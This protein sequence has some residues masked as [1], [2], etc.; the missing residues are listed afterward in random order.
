[1]WNEVEGHTFPEALVEAV[2][3]STCCV[4]VVLPPPPPLACRTI[5]LRDARHLLHHLQ[6]EC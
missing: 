6:V 4:L 2:P 3:S 5:W 1:M